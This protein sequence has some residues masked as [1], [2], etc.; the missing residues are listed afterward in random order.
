MLKQPYRLRALLDS[1]HG[2]SRPRVT[3]LSRHTTLAGA[4]RWAAVSGLTVGLFVDRDD[5]PMI[6]DGTFWRERG[7]R[8]E[9]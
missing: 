6:A 5:A 2:Y 3:T 4:L 1:R 7:A 9:G 8:Y